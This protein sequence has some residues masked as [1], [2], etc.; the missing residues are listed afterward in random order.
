[1]YVTWF[2]QAPNS[3]PYFSFFSFSKRIICALCLG[4]SELGRFCANGLGGGRIQ[5]QVE[6]PRVGH[7]AERLEL[8]LQRLVEYSCLQANAR[9]P[10]IRLFPGN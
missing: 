1:M 7:L 4:G 2:T 5:D 6:R 3:Y 9:F 10:E 8:L